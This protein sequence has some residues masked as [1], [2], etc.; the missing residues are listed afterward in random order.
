MGRRQ[1]SIQSH[2]ILLVDDEQDILDIQARVLTTAGY[3]VETACNGA[4]ALQKLAHR[5]YALVVTNMRMP[6]LGGEAFYHLLCSSFPH[7]RHRVVFCTGDIASADTLRFLT[8][9]GA[10]VLFKPFALGALV[11]TVSKALE[12]ALPDFSPEPGRRPELV[13]ATT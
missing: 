12:F 6:V 1:H 4:V 11:A 8:A 9:T 10:P 7:L 2:R 5:D 13:L 3:W